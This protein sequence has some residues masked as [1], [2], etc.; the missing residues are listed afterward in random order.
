[1]G[2]GIKSYPVVLNT[3]IHYGNI[4]IAIDNNY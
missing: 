3:I 2:R 1:M 4:I